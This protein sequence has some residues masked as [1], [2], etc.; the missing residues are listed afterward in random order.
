MKY[1]TV[2]LICLSLSALVPAQH[3]NEVQNFEAW[4]T[5]GV[6]RLDVQF[7]GTASESIYAL[8]GIRQEKY[9]SGPSDSL[10]DPFDYG[11]HK[12]VV[13]DASTGKAIYSKSYCT[14][15]REWQTTSEAQKVRRAFPHV[16]R[17]PWPLDKVKVEIYDRDRAGEFQLSW[18]EEIDPASIFCDPG[19]PME[20][21]SVDLE[22]HGD[23][24]GKIDI[25]FLAEGYT[26]AE[27]DKYLGD[28]SRSADY[29]F[30]E[31]P[32]RS[33]RDKFNI[34]AVKSY[35]KDSG[36]DIPGQGI[37]KNTVLNSSFYTFGIERYMTT[38]DF[39][40]VCDVASNAHYDQIY[41][42]VNTDKYG[43]GGIYN[44]YSISAA[45]NKASRAVV[46]HEFGHAF[47]GLA[48]E[49]YNSAVAYSDYFPLDVEPWNP[50]LTTLVD[51]PSKWKKSLD[52][53]IPVPTPE[54]DKYQ[55]KV[56]V[57]EGGGYVAKGVYRPMID[58]RMHTN[59]AV[60]CP[61]CSAALKRMMAVY[62]G[63]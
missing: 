40:S 16:L 26:E 15:Y 14:L 4:F 10:L 61:V 3:T 33:H 48:D 31:E 30:S 19:N 49:Y 11:D 34:R 25:L 41:I 32:F 24:S 18:D 23:A 60:F 53:E 42:L 35:S 22:I 46:I 54:D 57:F 21:E 62:T 63:Q 56:G 5:N 44:H 27:M 28:V 43:G 58:C 59:D 7:T 36:T 52:K 1:F 29:I 47:G 6:M 8:S 12:F 55:D 38:M 20:F 17:F 51:F 13:R 45:D 50:N 2:L 9:Y 39:K 37:W